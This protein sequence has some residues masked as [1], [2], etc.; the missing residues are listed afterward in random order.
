MD[1]YDMVVYIEKLLMVSYEEWTSIGMELSFT[2]RKPFNLV[3]TMKLMY[4]ND[5]LVEYR[6]LLYANN[7]AA[8]HVY[9]ERSL[10]YR[11]L[12]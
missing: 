7:L 6:L 11:I 5:E 12:F 8:E 10:T 2:Y 3:D 1:S 4:M 9:Y